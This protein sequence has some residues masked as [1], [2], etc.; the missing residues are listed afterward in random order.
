MTTDVSRE[1]KLAILRLMLQSRIGDE[2]EQA[3]KRR[4]Q[5]HFQLSSEGH[6]GLAGVALAMKKEDWL[7]PH[8]RDRAIVLGR[9]VT[10]EECFLDF[11]SKADSPTGGRQMPVH[12]SSRRYRIVSLSSPV[13]TNMLQAVGMAMSLKERKVPEVIVASIGDA[14]TREGETHEAIAQAGI[15]KLPIVFLIEDNR[16]GIST[17][18]TGKT[19]WTLPHGLA[20]DADGTEW[21]LGCRVDEVDGL[22]PVAVYQASAKAIERARCGDGP[23]CL[24]A[25]VERIKSHSSS[26]DQRVYRSAEELKEVTAKDP[27]RH[28]I[29][30]CVQEKLLTHPE[31]DALKASIKAEVEAAAARAQQAAEPDPNTIKG[32]AFAKL[33]DG[34]PGHEQHLP[35][36]LSKRSGG[37]TMAQCIDHT[38]E[39]EMRLNSRI[40][41]FGEDIEDPKGDVFGATRGL[42]RQFPGRVQ[43][44]PLA[45]ATIVGSAVGRALMGDLP[46]AAIQF[47]DFIGPGMNQ[48]FN[49]VSTMH[50]RSVG[51]WNCPMVI[52]APCGAYLPGLGPWHSQTNEAVYA[53]LPGVHVVMPSSPGDAAGLLRFALRCNRPVL[54]LYPKALLHGAEDTVQE[55]SVDCIVPFG[56]ARVVREGRDVT[57][58]AWGNCVTLCRAAATQASKEGVEAEI[59]DLRTITPWD[60]RAVFKS[61]I[62]TGRLIVVH[63]DNRTCGF[64]AEVIAETIGSAFEQLRAVPMRVTKTDDH[65]P[66]NYAMELAILPSVDGVLRAMREQVR[67]DLRPGRKVIDAGPGIGTVAAAI[68]KS[69]RAMAP[70]VV[71]APAIAPAAAVAPE[72]PPAVSETSEIQH[73]DILVPRQSPTDEDATLVR[74]LVDVGQPVKT[75]TPLLE[76][77]AN[78]GSFEVESTHDGVVAKLHAK[79]GERVKVETPVLTLDVAVAAGSPVPSAH[80]SA[81]LTPPLIKEQLISPAQM[82][83]GALALKSQHEI[84]TVSV[85]CEVD[86][87][88]AAK[89]REQLKREFETRFGLRPTFTHMILWALVKAMM[90]E[91]H[92]GFRGRLAPTADRLLIEP[93]ANIGFAAVGPNED[94]YSPVVRSADKL[95]FVEFM[96]RVHELTEKVRSGN[97]AAADLQGASVTL[98]NIGAFDAT[99]GT[100]FIIPGQL[101][102][103]T[104]GTVLERPR[105]VANSGNGDGKHLVEPRMLLNLKLVF[106]HRPFNGSHSASFLRTIKHIL[107]EMDLKTLMA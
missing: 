74:Y 8:Y 67:Q 72:M 10:Q 2:V 55:P 79:P 73:I 33:P 1:T 26:D 59:V 68:R 86:L 91:K 23:T 6:E 77:E 66:Y 85:E 96:R 35:H 44:S 95:T 92:Q 49:E 40:C 71:P 58:V 105:V 64:G 76:M 7:H 102:M 31:L 54:Y 101:A 94:L 69:E 42:S 81:R 38:L 104:S 106:D 34:L 75:G 22:D 65:I 62:K 52:M 100:P 9:G 61:V 27:V 20:K 15:D 17:P 98:T 46:V 60:S 82:Q 21:F 90:E 4:G 50:W 25:R 89:Q 30:R 5:G 14:S 51:Q 63:E 32:S 37:L 93:H 24:I 88:N 29:Q 87:T 11:Y 28:Y 3:L 12:Y 39:Q 84:P 36:F 47:I 13:A 41:V 16:W 78:K 56:Q 43:N 97:I 48:L 18:T 70:V 53:H 45:E 80:V 83:V 19:F 57:L 107:E 103:L 99:S